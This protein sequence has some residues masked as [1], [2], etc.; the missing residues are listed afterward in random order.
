MS[1]DQPVHLHPLERQLV[2]ERA[3]AGIPEDAPVRQGLYVD[4]DHPADLE[5]TERLRRQL[6]SSREARDASAE[7]QLAQLEAT[8]AELVLVHL[9]VATDDD[10]LARVE[11][12]LPRAALGALLREL[13]DQLDPYPAD[14]LDA[15]RPSLYATATA[16]VAAGY[17]AADAG[18]HVPAQLQL[19]LSEL[20]R[21]L[22][23]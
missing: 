21:A 13:A 3:A 6:A 16:A 8:A 2:E 1:D 18:Q 22:G 14:V 4:P 17:A 12:Q 10:Q 9:D 7:L 15:S 23:D 19:R 20:A 5:A 11:G